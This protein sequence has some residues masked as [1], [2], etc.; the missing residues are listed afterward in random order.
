MK[1]FIF[2]PIIF[3]A[4]VVQF[5]CFTNDKDDIGIGPVKNVELSALD[6]SLAEKGKAIFEMKC[7]SCHGAERTTA[8]PNLSGITKNKR[9][10]WIMNMILN[11]VQMAKENPSAKDLASKFPLKMGDQGLSTEDARALFEY[12]RMLDESK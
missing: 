10:E 8:G 12:L 5:S 1:K 6:K 11:P 3:F 9:P 2:V 4:S 7:R